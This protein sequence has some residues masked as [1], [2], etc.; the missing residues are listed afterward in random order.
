MCKVKGVIQ[1][2]LSVPDFSITFDNQTVCGLKA[3]NKGFK[4]KDKVCSLGIY[5][6]LKIVCNKF[7]EECQIKLLFMF[8]IEWGRVRC[9]HVG[10]DFSL[11]WYH[12]SCSKGVLP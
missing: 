11:L 4:V 7:E 1:N 10:K 5:S 2:F 6:L 3:G 9:V 8:L 12:S